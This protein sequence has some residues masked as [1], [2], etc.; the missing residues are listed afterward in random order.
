MSEYLQSAESF[1]FGNIASEQQIAAQGFQ[2]REFCSSN[3]QDCISYYVGRPL[4][5][6]KLK[7]QTE[8]DSGSTTTEVT[9]D[10]SREDV[11]EVTPATIVLVHGFRASKEFMLNTALYFRFLGYN[12]IVP[13]L[14][15]HGE[16][17]GAKAFGVGDSHIINELINKEHISEQPLY[18]LGNSMGAVAATHIA[19]MRNDVAGII[20][21]APM[22]DFDQAVLRYANAN[23][24]YLHRIMGDTSILEGAL[25]A[26][27]DA[28]LTVADTNI[29]PILSTLSIP[30]LILASSQDPVAP[31][32]SFADLQSNTI[33]V[34][35]LPNRNHPSMAIVGDD[36][37]EIILKWL[38]H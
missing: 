4:A 19:K 21:Q 15:G 5:S 27:T 35:D 30:T 8:L 36:S 10:I 1:D 24:P 16:S 9:L 33:T 18:L 3:A 6:K 23:H 7:Y 38:K 20:L 32:A 2:K 11:I 28:N 17:S 25:S 31:F 22:I 13:D 26:L 37:S 14:L 29:L 34:E 12:V